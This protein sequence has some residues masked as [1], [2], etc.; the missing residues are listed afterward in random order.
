MRTT[1]KFAQGQVGL[2]VN[3]STV[4]QIALTQV[5]R[6]YIEYRK[7]VM[8]HD[9]WEEDRPWG[10]EKRKVYDVEH[11][12]PQRPAYL[13]VT[14]YA[15]TVT[16]FLEKLCLSSVETSNIFDVPETK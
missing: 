8:A 9:K 10:D 5:V 3:L 6:P 7:M 13:D 14:K 4:D 16:V 11:P 2:D 15:D 1:K 12:E